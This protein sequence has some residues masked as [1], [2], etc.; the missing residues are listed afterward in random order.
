MISV[1]YGQTIRFGPFAE[2]FYYLTANFADAWDELVGPGFDL[3]FRPVSVLFWAFL[4]AVF[5]P[6]D[7]AFLDYRLMTIAMEACNAAAVALVARRIGYSRSIAAVAALLFAS[8]PNHADVV[9]WVSVTGNT[10]LCLLLS[11][12]ALYAFLVSDAGRRRLPYFISLIMMGAAMLTKEYAVTLPAILSLSAYE[13]CRAG[14]TIS[15]LR[16]ALIA[17][18]PHWLL[19]AAYV[20]AYRVTA[21]STP[22]MSM[23]EYLTV[24]KDLFRKLLIKFSDLA[25]PQEFGA[26]AGIAVV[27]ALIVIAVASRPTRVPVAW[28]VLML[29]PAS[30]FLMPHHL[31]MATAGSALVMSAILVPLVSRDNP[32]V[33]ILGV[34]M[35]SAMLMAGLASVRRR[36]D[37]WR[38]A[39]DSINSARIA[40]RAACA[41]IPRGSWLFFTNLP[42]DVRGAWALRN[43]ASEF[44]QQ[45]CSRT[46]IRTSNVLPSTHHAGE[47]PL[48]VQGLRFAAVILAGERVGLTSFDDSSNT[49]ISAQ[50]TSGLDVIDFRIIPQ[51]DT[52]H[53]IAYEAVARH[54]ILIDATLW[55]HLLDKE[56]A[57]VRN[58][59]QIFFRPTSQWREGERVLHV[60]A[61]DIPPGRYDLSIGLYG[62][63]PPHKTIPTVTGDAGVWRRNVVI[64]TDAE[65]QRTDTLA[66]NLLEAIRARKRDVCGA[67]PL[68]LVGL[69]DELAMRTSK[70][71]G[72]EHALMDL[73]RDSPEV[74]DIDGEPLAS[75]RVVDADTTNRQGVILQHSKFGFAILPERSQFGDEFSNGVSLVRWS[76]TPTGDGQLLLRFLFQPR[77]ALDPTPVMLFVH[78][79]PEKGGTPL[80]FD[81]GLT[82]PLSDWPLG[83]T[84]EHVTTIR[85]GPGRFQLRVGMYLAV[86]PHSTFPTESGLT[87]VASNSVVVQ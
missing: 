40:V 66:A 67:S 62:A 64:G 5:E 70:W 69:P 3:G 80:N 25:W 31:Y 20:G 12:S 28:C 68:L 33:R 35:L 51:T 42:D 65:R 34:L 75:D 26:A 71:K 21:R 85:T 43:G 23:S 45:T 15:A 41:D 56:R 61:V 4:N 2:D 73:C 17:T 19:L 83:K 18:S 6:K 22:Y 39:N 38:A 60:A 55:I 79:I 37:D 32:A 63:V 46:D 57:S 14:S 16:H 74:L 8:N 9:N 84:I 11:L 13:R 78:A 81:H 10:G 50:F 36:N 44:V 54:K 82:V 24:S 72:I 77:R 58:F 7:G 49:P 53:L 30:H 1:A 76:A 52:R 87:F 86:P 59:D 29:L 27:A 47:Y 48:P